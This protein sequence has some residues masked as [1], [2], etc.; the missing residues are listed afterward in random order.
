MLQIYLEYPEPLL[1]IS[2]QTTVEMF[3]SGSTSRKWTKRHEAAEP[4]GTSHHQ[5]AQTLGR[6]IWTPGI[7]HKVVNLGAEKNAVSSQLETGGRKSLGFVNSAVN[8][9]FIP[10]N[11]SM[12]QC[13][14]IGYCYDELH[15]LLMLKGWCSWAVSI[16][17]LVALEGK[18]NMVNWREILTE[19]FNCEK[20][21]MPISFQFANTHWCPSRPFV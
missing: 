5:L 15:L 16:F 7:N 10:P 8:C 11:I 6:I 20:A 18:G 19:P 17:C 14:S 4:A 3:L 9:I 2:W 21:N 13:R 12:Q 1:C